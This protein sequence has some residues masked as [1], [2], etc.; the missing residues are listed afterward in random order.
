MTTYL[1]IG[2]NRFSQV[3]IDGFIENKV[4]VIVIDRNEDKIKRFS[5]IKEKVDCLFLDPADL[6][7]LKEGLKGYDINKIEYAIV[8][9]KKDFGDIVRICKNL[10]K[11]GIE[12]VISVEPETEEEVEILS[13]I[14]LKKEGG[15]IISLEKEAAKQLVS[16][17]IHPGV[18]KLIDVEDFN[19]LEVTIPPGLKGKKIHELRQKYDIGILRIKR[20]GNGETHTYRPSYNDQVQEN[21]ILIVEGNPENISKFEEDIS[22]Q[23]LKERPKKNSNHQKGA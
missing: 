12:K 20:G 9:L 18:V 22:R 21:D 1:V 10:K 15:D 2:L 8:A 7:Q 19:V 11:I 23:T 13:D 3:C 14:G 6:D 5:E 16:R 17:L 4:P